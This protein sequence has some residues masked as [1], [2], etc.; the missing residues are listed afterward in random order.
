[1]KIKPRR[2]ETA[3]KL[4]YPT[5]APQIVRV[6]GLR[7]G[8]AAITMGSS[9]PGRLILLLGSNPLPNYLSPV[10]LQ[11]VEVVLVHTR[12]TEI[13]KDRLK[14]ELSRALGD[15]IR[16]V[17][18]DPFVDDATCATTVRRAVDRL[19]TYPDDGGKGCLAAA[20]VRRRP[21]CELGRR[22][23]PGAGAASRPPRC[24]GPSNRATLE[25]HPACCW[26]CHLRRCSHGTLTVPESRSTRRTPTLRWW[27]SWLPGG[28]RP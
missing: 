2:R 1:M 7:V 12:E 21:L 22:R 16:F 18:P 19:P 5:R 13:A 14:T 24:M 26:G 20:P 23:R 25:P 9:K 4:G 17:E 10:A 3:T 8:G 15:T 6:G 11:P 28:S 27:A